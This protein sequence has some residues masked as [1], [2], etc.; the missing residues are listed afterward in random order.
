MTPAG[1]RRHPTDILTSGEIAALL[2]RCSKRAP[3]GIR[4]RALIVTLHRGGLRISEALGLLPGHCDREAR[5]LAVRHRT[6]EQPRTLRLEPTDFAV[7]QRW[8]DT[9][10]VLG[11]G[12]RRPVFCTLEGQPLHPAYVRA[13]LPRLARK[14]G[15]AK[16]VHAFALRH[17]LAAEL[18]TTGTPPPV[19]QRQLGLSSLATTNRYLRDIVD[20]AAGRALHKVV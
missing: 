18:A 5:T 17:A 13:L 10:D 16:R 20:H 2:E 11:L 6:A 3:T 7:I 15:L 9:R 8:L 12:D 4:N 14:A 1:A 19:L